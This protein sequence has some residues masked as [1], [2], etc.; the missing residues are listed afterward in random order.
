[1]V[2][3]SEFETGAS[4]LDSIG[5]VDPLGES[6]GTTGRLFRILPIVSDS[7]KAQMALQPGSGFGRGCRRQTGAEVSPPE[8]TIP[9]QQLVERLLDTA[10]AAGLKPP[11]TPRE[12]DYLP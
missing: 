4:A 7:F 1:M 3:R 6:S 5:L 2:L 11:I 12:A 9:F 8:G 10:V